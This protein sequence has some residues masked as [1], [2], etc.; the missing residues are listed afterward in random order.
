MPHVYGV[1]ERA[2]FC[3]YM[4]M[5]HTVYHTLLSLVI[6]HTLW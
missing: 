4:Y 3:I 1:R 2:V 5:Y 6:V